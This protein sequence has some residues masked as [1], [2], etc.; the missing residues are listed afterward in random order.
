MSGP[1]LGLLAVPV[2]INIAGTALPLS[3]FKAVPQV[4]YDLATKQP[5]T[6]TALDAA[7]ILV[8]VTNTFCPPAALGEIAFIFLITHAKN[9]TN[10]EQQRMWDKAQGNL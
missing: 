1:L 2:Y 5:I 10:E 3:D 4:I 9:P 8:S 7:P 6:K